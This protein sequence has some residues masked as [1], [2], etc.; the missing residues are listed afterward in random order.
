MS[1]YITTRAIRLWTIWPIETMPDALALSKNLVQGIVRKKREQYVTIK[2]SKRVR[3][4]Q[5]S[6]VKTE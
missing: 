4:V 1:L 2:R 3:R 6:F 5:K